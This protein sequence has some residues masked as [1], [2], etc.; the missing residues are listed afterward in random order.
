[1]RSRGGMHSPE[2][3][4]LFNC[5]LDRFMFWHPYHNTKH[6]RADLWTRL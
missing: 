6:N 2:E 5:R 4:A 1:M 3:K